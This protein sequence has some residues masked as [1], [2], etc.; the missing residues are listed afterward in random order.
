[1][2]EVYF[3]EVEPPAESVPF[4]LTL[5]TEGDTLFVTEKTSFRVMLEVDDLKIYEMNLFVDEN[6]LK[7]DLNNPTYFTIEPLYYETGYYRLSAYFLTSSGSG[8]IADILDAEGYI[9]ERHWV[10][11]IENRPAVQ[12]TSVI[13][14]NS[15]NYLSVKWNKTDHLGFKHYNVIINDDASRRE[16]FI[17]DRNDTSFVDSCYKYGRVTSIVRTKWTHAHSGYAE[18]QYLNI[19]LPEVEFYEPSL[20]S[21]TVFWSKGAGN[22]L[23]HLKYKGNYILSNSTDTSITIAIPPLEQAADFYLIISTDPYENCPSYYESNMKFTYRRGSFFSSSNPTYACNKADQTLYTSFRRV[24]NILQANGI[25]TLNSINYLPLNNYYIE[26]GL[27]TQANSSKLALLGE[28][29]IKLFE[30]NQLTNPVFIENIYNQLSV[31]HFYYTMNNKIA[32]VQNGTYKLIDTENPNNVLTMDIGINGNTDASPWVGT[33]KD[34][35]FVTFIFDNGLKHYRIQNNSFTLVNESSSLYNSVL[36]SEIDPTRLFLSSANSIEI[37]VREPNTF[38]L[39][40]QIT[41]PEPLVIRN[42][43]PETGY[44]LLS[45]PNYIYVINPENGEVLLKTNT[46]DFKINLYGS[47]LFTKSGRYYDI[48]S[49]LP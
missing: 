47:K 28:Q 37:E 40:N 3:K 6:L 27:S 7:H 32:L 15:D 34:G 46:V 20:D 1:M 5:D 48:K 30:N 45:N 35:S 49:F 4:E 31:E 44:M 19:P 25:E 29:G 42:I 26:G 11:I 16:F 33:H 22:P 36:Y 39:I 18:P 12:P 10:L 38:E 14:I 13:S 17:Y 41:L 8:S 43:D 21:L 2:D 9:F 23:F 24:Y